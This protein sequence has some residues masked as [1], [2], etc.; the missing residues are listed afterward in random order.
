DLLGAHDAEAV[1][2]ELRD[3]DLPVA[4]DDVHGVV[5][6]DE[7]AVVVHA[8]AAAKVGA[9]V[10]GAL[11]GRRREDPGDPEVGAAD[12]VPQPVAL[13]VPQRRGPRA[14][15]VGPR[16][17]GGQVVAVAE[18]HARDR[19]ADGL[20]VD[21]VEGPQDR[22]PRAVVEVGGREVEG[23]VRADGHVVVRVVLVEHRVLEGLVA[24]FLDGGGGGGDGS[25]EGEE[26][27]KERD[28]A[29]RTH[30][31]TGT[32][33]QQIPEMQLMSLMP[34]VMLV[35]YVLCSKV[36]LMP[37]S[38]YQAWYLSFVRVVELGCTPSP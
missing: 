8:R 35:G 1:G 22:R 15:A 38:R 20:P 21:E 7:E 14:A 32:L 17:T 19:V 36:D 9:V 30:R 31:V 25:D 37:T 18:V 33:R 29:K 23:A 2:G 28:E 12:P 26:A 5:V 27:R 10:P 13:A 34:L 24:A 6:V 4:V 16:A 11:D 3:L